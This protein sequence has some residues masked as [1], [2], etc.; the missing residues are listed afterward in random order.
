VTDLAKLYVV[1]RDKQI[2]ESHPR[3]L[4]DDVG[5]KWLQSLLAMQPAILGQALMDLTGESVELVLLGT[6]VQVSDA[7]LVDLLFWDGE[8]PVIVE[9]KLF[10]NPGARRQV[11]AQTLDYSTALMEFTSDDVEDLVSEAFTEE[12]ARQFSDP[13]L[14]QRLEDALSEGNLLLVIVGDRVNEKAVRLAKAMFADELGSRL[15]LAF[16]ELQLFQRPNGGEYDVVSRPVWSLL[17]EARKVLRFRVVDSAER[18]LRTV[19]AF[20]DAPDEEPAGR[21]SLLVDE[22]AEVREDEARTWVR[23]LWQEGGRRFGWSEGKGAR[24][25]PVTRRFKF[26]PFRLKGEK[27]RLEIQRKGMQ[28]APLEVWDFFVNKLREVAGEELEPIGQRGSFIIRLPPRAGQALVGR[29]CDAVVETENYW[30]ELNTIPG[31][32]PPGE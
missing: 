26:I 22:L 17:V 24:T 19:R 5:E 18:E 31:G 9:A 7:G 25:R 3:C 14:R 23:A 13:E 20:E 28:R 2:R 32:S 12:A 8:R 15:E 16:V 11:L 6:E 30:Q 27:S 10:G 1:T 29:I 4:A 21:V